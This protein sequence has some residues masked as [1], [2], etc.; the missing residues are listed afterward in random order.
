M[1]RGKR[2]AKGGKA[3]Q[4]LAARRGPQALPLGPGSAAWPRAE[5]RDGGAG[6]GRA[7]RGCAGPGCAGQ[8]QARQSRAGQGR[9]VQGRAG[10][11]WAGPGWAGPGR[12]G[13]KAAPQPAAAP[14]S[15]SGTGLAR[16]A[17]PR[18]R[19]K[20]AGEAVG[21]DTPVGPVWRGRRRKHLFWLA[22]G[23]WVLLLVV[24]PVG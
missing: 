7:G 12:V 20:E 6:A 19:R 23:C 8:G 24:L 17:P 13:R 9:A 3:R 1:R 4:R 11:G 16:E 22:S 2:R 10:P 15:E 18:C 14:V 21:E 5:E